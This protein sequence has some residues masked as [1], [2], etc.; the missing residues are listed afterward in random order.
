[1]YK[2]LSNYSLVKKTIL[3]TFESLLTSV[4]YCLFFFSKKIFTC[5]NEILIILLKQRINKQILAHRIVIPILGVFFNNSQCWKFYAMKFQ[6]LT[7]LFRSYT[8]WWLNEG[9][10]SHWMQNNHRYSIIIQTMHYAWQYAL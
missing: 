8:V 9:N 5:Y 7:D 6:T 2:L 4:N 3:C 10:Q 1:M